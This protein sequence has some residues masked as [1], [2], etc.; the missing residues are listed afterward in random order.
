MNILHHSRTLL[1]DMAALLLPRTC[2]VCNER[3]V[4]G[5]SFVCAACSAQWP[6]YPIKRIDDNMI[7]RRLWP[8]FPAVYG[9]T[10]FIYRHISPFHNILMRIKYQGYTQL[11]EELGR[12]G[13]RELQATALPEWTDILVPVPLSRMRQLKRG[14]NQAELIAR[15]MARELDRP[16]ERL[17]RRKGGRPS[18]THL[19]AKE[20]RANAQGIYTADIPNHLRGKHILL[21]DD[22]ITTGATLIACATALLEA[23]PTAEISVFTLASAS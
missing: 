18:Q 15:G 19:G 12:W 23:D 6:H 4:Q 9:S 11:A 8:S 5:E 21:V 14:Y 2:P 13:G 20:R 22:V 10:L 3:M 16:V 17:L 7:V 1:A